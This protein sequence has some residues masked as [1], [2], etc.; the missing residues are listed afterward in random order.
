MS[1]S[2]KNCSKMNS[3]SYGGYPLT[4]SVR[5]ASLLQPTRE[6]RHNQ[7]NHALLTRVRD[8]F[9]AGSVDRHELRL[10]GSEAKSGFHL[11]GR[12][13]RIARPMHE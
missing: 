12:A 7:A 10:G 9:M 13:E 1:A 11:L 6:F 3:R 8:Y 4:Q 5:G 2:A